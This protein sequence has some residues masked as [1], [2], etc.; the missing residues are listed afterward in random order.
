M[1]LLAPVDVQYELIVADTGSYGKTDGGIFSNSKMGKALERKK[2]NVPEEK[3]L[4]AT[5]DSLPHVIADD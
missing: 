4:A 2:L 5:T 3:P 1:V